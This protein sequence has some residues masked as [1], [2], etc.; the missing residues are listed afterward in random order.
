MVLFCGVVW[1]YR[2][3]S[4]R[5]RRASSS[6]IVSSVMSSSSEAMVP[7]DEGAVIRG[8]ELLSLVMNT[9]SLNVEARQI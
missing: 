6:V 7:G 9:S 1:P 3:C 8:M 2:W 4:I 5:I